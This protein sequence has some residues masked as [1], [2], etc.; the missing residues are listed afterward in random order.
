MAPT[1]CAICLQQCDTIDTT[2][3]PCTHVFCT[4]CIEQWYCQKTTCPLCRQSL[5]TTYNIN[6]SVVACSVLLHPLLQQILEPTRPLLQQ[7]VRYLHLICDALHSQNVCIPNEIVCSYVNFA[8]SQHL[9]IAR[10][11]EWDTT[12]ANQPYLKA[13]TIDLDRGRHGIF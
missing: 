12:K 6:K 4:R 2:R 8:T 5:I 1:E 9:L 7:A 11:L 10:D 13:V 3:L